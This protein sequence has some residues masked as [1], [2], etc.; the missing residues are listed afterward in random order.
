MHDWSGE[1]LRLQARVAELQEL[2]GNAVGN[3]ERL[4]LALTKAEARIAELKKAL[5][6][7]ADLPSKPWVDPVDDDE[8]QW[9]DRLHPYHL[10]VARA[11]SA[12]EKIK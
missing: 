12:L 5:R 11:R 7:I 2:H 8:A 3:C 4:G 6:Y 10:A 9:N 1:Y